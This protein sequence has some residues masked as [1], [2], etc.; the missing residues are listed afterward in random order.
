V[1]DNLRSGNTDYRAGV[2]AGAEVTCDMM[3]LRIFYSL[4]AII[5]PVV[6]A[7]SGCQ[8]T[9]KLAR[10]DTPQAAAEKKSHAPERVRVEA[11][12][13]ADGITAEQIIAQYNARNL[14]SPG[15]RR[16][17]M[18]LS[19]DGVVTRDFSIINLWQGDG[20]E[21][22]TLFLLESPKGLAGTGYLLQEGAGLTSGMTI[23]LFIPAGERRVLEVAR[24]NFSEGLLGSDFSY[25][26]MRMWTPIEGFD[27]QLAGQAVLL[28]EAVW[29]VS[30]KPL[31]AQARQT[32]SCLQARYYLARKF[33]FML[34]VD[35]YE[36]TFQDEAGAVAT[37]QMRVES[38]QQIEKVWTATRMTMFNSDSRATTL[39]L[40]EAHFALPDFEQNLFL[41]ESLPK[42]G[43]A[44]QE[45]WTPNN[46]MPE[47]TSA[48]RQTQR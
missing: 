22:R 3:R 36:Q 16:V 17:T 39:T 33:P 12:T 28:N 41:P 26:D 38:L 31:T 34:G 20:G 24:N 40:Q 19:T 29:V 1:P 48:N 25:Q 14:G 30:A 2:G 5:T 21:L 45:G 42:L 13:D 11:L 8:A 43:D 4:L 15:W 44:V 6:F 27:Y 47:P 18:E 23:H 37:K 9:S 46:S 10:K 7:L 32:C 35:Y